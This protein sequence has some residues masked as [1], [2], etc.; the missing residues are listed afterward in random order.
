MTTPKRQVTEISPQSPPIS[1]R[2][3]LKMAY[4]PNEIGKMNPQKFME[5]I[6]SLIDGKLLATKEDLAENSKKFQKIED[7]IQQI[8]N[9]EQNLL[10]EIEKLKNRNRRCNLIIKGIRFQKKENNCINIVADFCGTMLNLQNL[11]IRKAYW[12]GQNKTAIL[13]IFQNDDDVYKILRE[14]KKL[15][16]TPYV[17]HRDY[18]K[19]TRERRNKLFQLKKFIKTQSN[20]IIVYVRDDFICVRDTK[21]WLTET[22][23]QL[24][25][26]N[27]GIGT[28]NEIINCDATDF[29]RKLVIEKERCATAEEQ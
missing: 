6:S 12:I 24:Y 22:G 3:Q 1:K 2:H 23:I 18:E 25:N 17:I 16:N 29:V 13:A 5:E 7:E 11:N 15:K 27:D 9:N 26:K 20:E 8:K 4:I 21:F 19:I 10:Y 28:L 14:G